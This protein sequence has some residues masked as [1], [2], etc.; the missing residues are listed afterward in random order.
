MNYYLIGIKGSGMASLAKVLKSAGHNVVGS[1]IDDYIYTQ[2]SLKDFNIY[3]LDSKEY[4]K[5]DY[6]IIGHN[7]YTEELCQELKE[8][9]INYS[10]Y[11]VFL[12]NYL[13]N[14]NLVSICGSHG[15]TTLTSMLAY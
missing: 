4:L 14:R 9:N 1:D 15:K 8:N 10:E 2:D 6:V 7:F 11:N 12:S 13:K 5:A 3:H